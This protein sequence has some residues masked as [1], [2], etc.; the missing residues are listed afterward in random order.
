VIDVSPSTWCVLALA[1]TAVH[2]GFQVTVTALVYP[3]LARTAPA[4]WEDAHDRHSRRIAP[5]VAVVYVAA[6]VSV[7]GAVLSRP[8]P[9]TVVAAVGTL[10]TVGVTAALAAPLHGRLGRVGADPELLRRL[11]VVDR[12]RAVGAVVALAGAVVAVLA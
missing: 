9:G 6:L 12:V 3:A 2:A 7:V 5:I 8:A 11:L 1:A 10:V 4:L